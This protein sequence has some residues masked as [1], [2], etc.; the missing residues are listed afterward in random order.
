MSFGLV[1][2]DWLAVGLDIYFNS[3]NYG[4]VILNTVQSICLGI[5]AFHMIAQYLMVKRLV[6]LTQMEKETSFLYQRSD[7]YPY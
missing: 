3:L 7:K 5:T 1:L 6:E 4:A 2:L